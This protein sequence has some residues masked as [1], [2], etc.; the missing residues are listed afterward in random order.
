VDAGIYAGLM[1]GLN[2]ALKKKDMMDYGCEK[3]K[4]DLQ[5][6]PGFMQD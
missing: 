6:M 3:L 4:I 5:W 1:D 2:S